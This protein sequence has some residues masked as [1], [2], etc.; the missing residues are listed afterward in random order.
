VY[1]VVVPG[2]TVGENVAGPKPAHTGIF[3]VSVCVRSMYLAPL[4]ESSYTRHSGG[5]AADA[6]A[7]LANTSASARRTARKGRIRGI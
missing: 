1:G 4:R 5:L 7:A 6:V 3:G 2:L